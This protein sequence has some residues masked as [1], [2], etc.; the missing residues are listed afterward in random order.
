[1]SLIV[2]RLPL[3]FT[4]PVARALAMSESSSIKYI[5]LDS[6]MGTA[7]SAMRWH[8][9]CRNIISHCMSIGGLCAAIIIYLYFFVVVCFTSIFYIRCAAPRMQTQ[10]S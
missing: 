2:T 8:A 1:M 4:S 5:K 7:A 9:M 6:Y 10:L 3:L